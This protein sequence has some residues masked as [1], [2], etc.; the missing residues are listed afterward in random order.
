MKTIGYLSN[1]Y[2]Y[3]LP[4]YKTGFTGCTNLKEVEIQ[5]GIETIYGGFRG[6][7]LKE[8]HLPKSLKEYMTSSVEGCQN[9]T[10][11]YLPV[12]KVKLNI[13]YE[14]ELD[15]QGWVENTD[16]YYSNSQA[17]LHVPFGAAKNYESWIPREF[18]KIEEMDPQDGDW[19][20]RASRSPLLPP[21]SPQHGTPSTASSFIRLPPVPACISRTARKLL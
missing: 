18:A 3:N 2:N 6:T 9:L 1:G 7:A 19:N 13:S 17:T 5:E 12:T 15:W 8:L 14:E 10:D 16:Y 20:P 21:R 4:G 11:V